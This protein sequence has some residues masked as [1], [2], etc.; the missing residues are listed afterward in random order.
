MII[1]EQKFAGDEASS[2]KNDVQEVK[3]PD[4]TA[5]QSAV[6]KAAQDNASSRS[7]FPTSIDADGGSVGRNTSGQVFVCVLETY[8]EHL[9]HSLFQ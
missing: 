5:V 9:E 3:H 2:S 6:T 1:A 7:T 4:Q 8:L